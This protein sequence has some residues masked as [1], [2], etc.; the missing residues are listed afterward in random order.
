MRKRFASPLTLLMALSISI[1]LVGCVNLANLQLARL[2]ARGAE[3]SIRIAL[4]AGRGCFLRQIVLEDVVL[5]AGGSAC[6]FI[7]GRA[8]CGILVAWASNRNSL[9]TIDL[10]PNLPL[11]VFGIALMLLSL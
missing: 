8:A 7:L 11:M 5:V 2:H 9:F 4:G 3:I 1:F 6:A 10:H